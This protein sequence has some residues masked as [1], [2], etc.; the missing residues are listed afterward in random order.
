MSKEKAW[1]FDHECFPNLFS[2]TLE[3]RE[4]DEVKVFMIC[5]EVNDIKEFVNFIMSSECKFM[6]GFNNS[7]YDDI[8]TNYLVTN[9]KRLSRLSSDEITDKLFMLSKEI[10][11]CQRGNNSIWNN[12]K[13]KKLMY[14]KNYIPIDLMTLMAFDKN[15]VS[16]K[17]ACIAMR[18]HRIQDLP[19]PFDEQVQREEVEGILDYNLNDVKATKK[20][21]I[22]VS[23]EIK[24][25][26]D[27]GAL[28][29]VQVLSK[30]RSGLGDTLMIKL[31][32][33]ETRQKYA[34]FKGIK[35][36]RSIIHL[37]DCISDKVKFK[38]PQLQ[39]LLSKIKDT[40]WYTGDKVKFSVILNESKYD[41]LLGGLH[42][43]N[44]PMV[45]E[46]T[47][48]YSL[49]DFD[50]DSYY[51]RL[52]TTLDIYPEHLSKKFLV[53]F[54]RIITQRLAAKANGEKTVANALKIV[55]NACYGKLNFD[56]GWIKDT[57]ASYSVTLNGQL[58][59][60]MLIEQLEEVGITIFYANTDGATA[61]V[62]KGKENLFY[63]ICK[64]F[65][66]YVGI[67]ISYAEYEKCIIRDV[68][69]YSI[70]DKDGD[71]KE[72]GVFLRDTNTVKTFLRPNYSCAY[73]KPIISIAL[74][75]YFVNKVPIKETIENHEDIYD[76]CMAQKIGKQFQAETHCLSKDK[77][78]LVITP[79]QKTNRYYVS[80][81][82][83]KFY[84][85][86]KEKDSLHDLCA[87]YNVELLNDYIDQNISDYK[88]NY[89]Y[90]ITSA[91]KIIDIM[92]PRQLELF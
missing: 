39:D 38:S 76:F 64:E 61:K 5:R 25:R 14:T 57:K 82:Q 62:P 4:S 9:V 55:I 81:T 83:S 22:I 12:S 43:N 35:T 34:E 2:C 92:E 42:S 20:L 21:C 88:V 10:I 63:S 56:Y 66:D 49:K 27:I 58:Y 86:H 24:I 84:K 3:D 52:M 44:K 6:V 16:L 33:Q 79:S 50:F 47:D 67:G 53:L 15:F 78:E 36:E 30:S 87:G 51:P 91:Q 40:T 28:Y 60:L 72:K 74:Y 90:Y 11:D 19:K 45:V 7:K 8:I 80:K 85:K 75:E 32:E 26:F 23:Q 68:N 37:K 41:I 73:D 89:Q 65:Q 70:L 13:L 59:L 71:I 29:N 77:L 54:D 17:Q 31:W 18:W 46:A 1:V 48:E 69:N